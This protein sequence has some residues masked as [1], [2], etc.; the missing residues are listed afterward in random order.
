MSPD[1]SQVYV[2]ANA[3]AVS[4]INT[5]TKAVTTIG[6]TGP[7]RDLAVTPDGTKLYLA[8]EYSGLWQLLTATSAL[9]QVSSQ[10]C[11]EGVAVTPSGASLYVSYQCGGPG[12]SS[13]HDAIGLFNTTTNTFESSITGLPN[14][15]GLISM[16]PNGLQFWENGEDACISSAYNHVGCPTTPGVPESVINVIGTSTN[17]LIRSLGGVSGFISFF[18][19]SLHVFAVAGNSVEVMDTSSLAVVSTVPVAG[20]GSV[21]FVPG[22]CTAYAPVPSNNEVVVLTVGS[23]TCSC[24]GTPGPQGPPGPEGPQGPQGL[25]GPAGPA[26]PTGAAGPAGPRGPQGP[27]GPAGVTSMTTITQNYSGSVDLSCPS[28]Y[29]A[30]VAS[31][32]TGTS[33]ILN[34][35]TP[36]PPVGSWVSYLT[37]SVAAAT[38]VHCNLGSAALRSQALLRCAK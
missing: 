28:G 13:G 14:V 30:V 36:V 21:A 2:A 10:T 31:C 9:S 26:G 5:S 22:G 18:P 35:K 20:S 6:T 15:G 32:N 33:V 29:F 24:A 19:D 16:A 17:M 12:G 34:G 23:G 1:G 37:P 38:G 11:P 25:Q 3:G 4:I 7:V 27:Q 8:M